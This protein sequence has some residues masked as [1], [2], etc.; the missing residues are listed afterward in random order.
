MWSV[1]KEGKRG[2]DWL[3]KCT[4]LSQR[5]WCRKWHIAHEILDDR[6]WNLKWLF[7]SHIKV[8]VRNFQ[9]FVKQSQCNTNAL[10]WPI[11]VFNVIG[12]IGPDS[13]QNLMKS[14][15]FTRNPFSPDPPSGAFDPPHLAATSPPPAMQSFAG[16]RWERTPTPS[17]WRPAM[18]GRE[19]LQ[20]NQDWT[21][22][23]VWRLLQ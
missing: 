15:R 18:L 9:L 22:Q 14:C 23:T 17:C 13:T 21:E 7:F 20:E 4:A 16:P 3:S 10:I 8:A 2:H 19:A 5:Q 1:G 11:Q 12:V 6:T